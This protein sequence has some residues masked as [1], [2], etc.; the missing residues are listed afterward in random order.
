MPEEHN[1]IITDH[2]SDV[3]FCPTRTAVS[4]LAREGLEARVELV[5]DTMY[6]VVVQFIEAAHQRSTLLKDLNLRPGEYFLLTVHRGYN[7]D[8]P[9]HLSHILAALPRLG[10][11][12]IFPVHPRTRKMIAQLNLPCPLSAAGSRVIMLDPLGYF[13]MLVLEEHARAILT[14]SGGMQKE[15]YFLGVPCLTLRP[16]T[17]WVE[18]LSAGWNKLVGTD[19]DQIVEA[20]SKVTTPTSEPERIF[21]QGDAAERIRLSLEASGG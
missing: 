6:D 15:A 19:T 7:A 20:C 18:T 3:L 16:E 17:E 5:G 1:R 12:V 2:C 13:D 8:E 10:Y 11:P 9:D 21:G 14:D 4:N